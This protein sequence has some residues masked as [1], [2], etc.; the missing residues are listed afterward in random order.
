MPNLNGHSFSLSSRFIASEVKIATMST[1]TAADVFPPILPNTSTRVSSE[2][3]SSAIDFVNRLNYIFEENDTARMTASFVP[4]AKV[5]HF[6]GTLSGHAEIKRFLETTYTYLLHGVSRHATN[7][8]VDRDEETGCVRVRYHNTLT[9]FAWPDEAKKI[10][11]K[12]AS[13]T[14]SHDGLPCIWEWSPMIDR[15]VQ[16]EDGWKVNKRWIGGSVINKKLDGDA[17]PNK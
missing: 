4:D 3:R 13:V 1:S 10:T 6:L 11:G 16:T 2:E 15:L 9:R 7:H 8:I 17:R 12:A 14:E 5:Q